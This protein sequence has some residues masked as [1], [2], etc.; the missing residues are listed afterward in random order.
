MKLVLSLCPGID[1]LGKG[2]EV[3]GF[4]VVKGPDPIFGGDI[5]NFSAPRA[6][7]AGVIVGSPCQDFS[8][9]RRSVPPTGEG[10][11]ILG[12]CVRVIEETEPDWFLI[13][14]VPTVPDVIIPGY[15]IQRLD[16]NANECGIPQ[17]RLRHFQFGSRRGFIIEPKRQKAIE[18]CE[19]TCIAT[20][21][22]REGRRMW[23]DFCALQGLP[24]DF[25]LPG[26]T[27]EGR[28]KAVGNGVPLPMASLIARAILE[29]R[30]LAKG[31]KL[32][33]CSCGRILTGKQ[34][35][36]LPACRKRLERSRTRPRPPVT[37]SG[38]KN[39]E[40]SHV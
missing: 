29:A 25:H 27:R 37:A 2:F 28:Y 36:A 5:R 10:R 3:E 12:H 11:E 1:L 23:G 31:E 18:D 30:P 20:E 14:N 4:C 32:C 15:A 9:A 7:F 13:E 22:V 33:A 16:L 39:A 24:R 35:A 21:G 38:V 17:N 26:W 40:T 8:I 6:A 19:R 34:K